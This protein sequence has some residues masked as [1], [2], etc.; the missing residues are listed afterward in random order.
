MIFYIID[1]ILVFGFLAAMF[2]MTAF[3]GLLQ[4]FLLHINLLNGLF[5]GFIV[6]ILLYVNNRYAPII[7]DSD[8]HPAICLAVGIIVMLIA[9]LIQRTNVGF[10]IFTV[11]MSLI[12]AGMFAFLTDVL[13]HDKIWV[14]VTFVFALPINVYSHIRS[15]HIRLS[16]TN[17]N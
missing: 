5:L 8:I 2:L 1:L 17:S 13:T 9:I 12:W 4:G 14:I 7:L 10:W 3:S 15:R 11:L 6:G 16:L